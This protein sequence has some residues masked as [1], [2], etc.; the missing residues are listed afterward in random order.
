[1]SAAAAIPTPTRWRRRR[2]CRALEARLIPCEWTATA[3]GSALRGRRRGLLGGGGGQRRALSS[4]ATA[5]TILDERVTINNT[6]ES[7]HQASHTSSQTTARD[8]A[9]GQA[10]KAGRPDALTHRHT[11]LIPRGVSISSRHRAD[12]RFEC[13]K[14][15]RKFS[16]LFACFSLRKFSFLS[17]LKEGRTRIRITEQSSLFI[18][19]LIIRGAGGRAAAQ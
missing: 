12:T 13:E 4:N 8:A 10:A 1:V 2:N 17:F 9:G 16:A 5:T 3:S 15:R 11:S 7:V 19:G 6:W 18:R 14:W